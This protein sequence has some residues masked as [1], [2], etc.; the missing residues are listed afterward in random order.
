M[1]WYFLSVTTENDLSD[2][3]ELPKDVNSKVGIHAEVLPVFVT[4]LA[5]SSREDF[6]PVSTVGRIG[7]PK[8]VADGD[9]PPAGAVL[10]PPAARPPATRVAIF[11]AVSF[12]AS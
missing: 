4:K 9:P 11:L 6:S 2:I 8:A 12:S 10:P 5:A 1:K 7:A 3:D